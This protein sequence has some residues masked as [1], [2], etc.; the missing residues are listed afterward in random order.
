M[1][2]LRRLLES[3]SAQLGV[4]TVSQRIAIG[5]CAA[6]IVAS[7]LWLLQW[8]TTP[9]MVSLVNYRFTFDDMAD[10]E[11]ALKA[12]SIP[13]TI[14]G[15]RVYIREAD[16]H[17]ALRVLHANGA[18][19]EGS[20]F[21]MADLVADQN[22]FQSPDARAYAQNYAKGNELAKII[23]TN[24]IVESA[25]V[26]INPRTKRRLGGHSDVPSATVAVTLVRGNEMTAERVDGFARL[27]S[28]A[29]AG[30]Q[31]YNVNI[32]DSRTG[33]SFS[34]PHPEDAVAFDYLSIVKRHEDRLRAKIL[35]KLADIPG[36]RAT[37]TVKL[38]TS[39]KTTQNYSYAEPQPKLES[40][41]SSET[42]EAARPSESGVQANVGTAVTAGGQGASNSSEQST[43]ENY[44]PKL[45]ET[46]T[47]ERMPF[48]L[49]NVTATVGIPR[50]FIVGVFAA[51][52]PEESNP[53]DDDPKFIAVRDEQT[54]RVQSSVE[55]I[56]MAK[57]PRDVHVDV[58]PDM[59][60]RAD[61][62]A[63]GP[64]PGGVA[65]S[66]AGPPSLDALGF[67]RSYGPL[68]GLSSLALI[69]MVMMMRMVRRSTDLLDTRRQDRADSGGQGD[70]EQFLTVGPRAIGQ[71]EVSEGLLTGQEV[72][73]VALRQ[74]ELSG[75]VSKMIEDD[76]SIAADLIR[77]WV[78]ES[79]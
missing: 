14:H 59:G 42:S 35:E 8:S 46:E 17:N 54:A 15:T 38:D 73:E 5:L 67:V 36:L 1:E 25:S 19:P 6:L 31:P 62:A 11:D 33:R 45:S 72:D 26:L 16:R 20:L 76:P 51:R 37:V 63:V 13:Y 3:I 12:N 40:S 7:V 41:E 34:I 2:R 78:E 49:Q 71:A 44:E 4:L 32:T 48:T 58:Y 77:R 65:V 53:K 55:K 24:P 68:V 18:L 50:S 52:H 47:V 60:W 57:D 43:T 9:E 23:A 21:D 28:G 39:K 79:E 66:Q 70:P 10:V 22:P 29:V 64:L 56:V 30:L 27:V 61:G 74:Q 75:E 69:S